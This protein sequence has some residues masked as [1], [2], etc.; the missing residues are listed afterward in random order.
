MAT[1]KIALS[2]GDPAEKAFGVIL[3]L[4]DDIK[5]LSEIGEK[6]EQLRDTL[7]TQI[8]AINAA[9]LRYDKE[10]ARYRRDVTYIN[11]VKTAIDR[12][13]AASIAGH[14]SGAGGAG[15]ATFPSGGCNFQ[16]T[17]QVKNM[18]LSIGATGNVTSANLKAIHDEKRITCGPGGI[19][20]RTHSFRLI[21]GHVTGNRI[22]ADFD[23]LA[24]KPADIASFVGVIA[25]NLI[26]GTLTFQRKDNLPTPLEWTITASQSLHKQ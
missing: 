4:K 19:G 18:D 16:T 8:R 12:A 17:I 11:N 20:L 9:L 24:N 2:K 25:G 10:M 3:T 6:A 26:S 21:T 5:E 15:T 7:D 22:E 23:G 13:C 1:L 14:W